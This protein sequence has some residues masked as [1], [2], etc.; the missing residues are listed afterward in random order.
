VN[1]IPVVE[2]RRLVKRFGSVTAL[3][4][5]DLDIDRGEVF[6]LIGP[7][8]AGKTTFIRAVVGAL[9]LTDGDLSVLGLGPLADR[10]ELRRRIGYMPQESA[11]YPDLSARRN[12][13]FFSAAHTR[14]RDGGDVERALDLVGLGDR[15]DDPVRTLSGGMQ[16]RVSLGCAM[17]HEPELL[18]L[19]E[20]TAGVDPE[21][22]A[23]FWDTFHR[24]AHEGTTVI[25][26]THQMGEALECDRVALLQSG[27]VVAAEDPTTLLRSY[28]ATVHL[29][30]HGTE[31]TLALEDYPDELP[32]VMDPDVDR[33]EID[34]EPLD[35]VILGL[36][37]NG[38][39]S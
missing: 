39:R 25:V 10:W 2:G 34:L 16:Q 38:T 9:R 32:T 14:E 28:R 11:L 31:Q 12:I 3:A 37:R 29:W 17:A 8:G 30:R 22:R 1:D 6:G 4:G 20:P 13:A 26:S 23:T 7:N 21:L 36:I 18:I 33:V 19:D 27:K 15:S 35:H 24:M 5:I